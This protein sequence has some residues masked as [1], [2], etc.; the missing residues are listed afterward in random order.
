[1]LQT[2]SALPRLAWRVAADRSGVTAVVTAISLVVLMGFAG[3]A[4]DV[5]K[6]L[7]ATRDMQSAADQGAYSA[8][9]AAG[10]TGCASTA[11]LPQAKAI[12][13]ARGYIDGQKDTK[14]S[15]ACDASRLRFTVAI[16]Q[17]QPM[18]FSRLFLSKPPVASASAVAR[19]A[20]K[21]TDLC[22]L[23][24]DGTSVEGNIGS[25]Q[26][27]AWSN[28]STNVVLK[29]GLAVDSS[30]TY[31]FEASGSSNLTATD[32]YLVGNSGSFEPSANIPYC[33]SGVTNPQGCATTSPT[34][35]NVL[36]NQSPVYDPYAGRT[37][38]DL[39]NEPA[40]SKYAC[41]TGSTGTS[42][43]KDTTLNPGVYCGGLT[44]GGTGKP[45]V[46]LNDGIYY[47]VGGQLNINKGTITQQANPNTSDPN[48]ANG[49]TF[50]LTGGVLGQPCCA[51]VSIG[52]NL[53]L[54]V[55]APTSGPFGG[56]A[57]FGDRALAPALSTNNNNITCGNGNAQEQV[58]GG[59][60]QLIN[61]AIY[62]PNQ[63]MCY[64]GN[65]ATTGAG[66]CTQLIAYQ[67]SFIGTSNLQLQCA[68]TGI[69]PMTVAV[70]QLVE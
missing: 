29:C 21:V 63:T 11:A 68:G 62:F 20:S 27:A 1:M 48:Y 3:L 23:A 38:P 19:V 2:K 45:K 4:I 30:N 52:G 47:I 35:N 69:S 36:V 65:A 22:V 14:V 6:W 32:I 40:S 53:N 9:L 8:A 5:G 10:Q 70:P 58:A 12:V 25:N 44:I 43:S 46:V 57:F 26:D 49:V 66:R 59:G 67:I 56:I 39:T 51:T 64:S 18:W 28:G 24:L 33:P 34:A 42:V 61:G 31:A 55:Q 54:T 60:S 7:T 37:I 17:P 41:V 15:A 13:A 50:V 16:S